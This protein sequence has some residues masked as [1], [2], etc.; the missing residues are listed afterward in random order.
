MYFF[1]DHNLSQYL[2]GWDLQVLASFFLGGAE[3]L[4]CHTE[5]IGWVIG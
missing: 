4:R 1:Y 2:S 3:A 5:L